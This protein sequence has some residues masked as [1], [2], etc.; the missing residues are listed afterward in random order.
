MTQKIMDWKCPVVRSFY[1]DPL[2]T[3]ATVSGS[4]TAYWN[5]TSLK[6]RDEQRPFTARLSVYKTCDSPNAKDRAA[7]YH[8]KNCMIVRPLLV[9]HLY[10]NRLSMISEFFKTEIFF[11]I[12]FCLLQ[13]T[14][15]DFLQRWAAA[16]LWNRQLRRKW[17]IWSLR[18]SGLNHI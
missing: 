12:F 14:T 17:W 16:T 9:C 13:Q 6:L 10:A 2:G 4:H 5:A 8:G 15:F 18:W 3:W 1:H 7:K 11:L